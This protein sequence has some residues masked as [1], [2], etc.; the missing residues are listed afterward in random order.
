[1]KT[2]RRAALCLCLASS[3]LYACGGKTQEGSAKDAEQKKGSSAAAEEKA[4][5]ESEKQGKAASEISFMIP[6][7]GVPT[8]EML[9][10]F[11]E[12]SGVKVNVLTTGWDDIRNKISTA[13]AGKTAAADVFEV[14]WSWVGEFQKAGWIAPISLSQEDMDDMVSAKTFSVDGTLYAVPYSNDYRIAYYNKNMFDQA[15]IS[16]PPKTWKEVISDAKLLK[17]KGI[18]EYPVSNP[19]SAD[20]KST[21]TFLWLA[22]T[23]DGKVFNED[24]T[25]NREA[26]LD[27]LN[28]L[29]EINREGLSDPANRAVSEAFP[30]LR[31]G[32][33]AFMVGPSSNVMAVNDPR[34]SKV[35]G[36]V[37]PILL[38][39]KEAQAEVTTPFAEAVGI[40]PYSK[41]PEG[42]KK[43]VEWYSSPEV[44][45]Q[46]YEEISNLPTRTSVLEKLLKDGKI[47]NPGAML[48]LAK[49]IES[50]FPN[51]VPI[52][53]TRMS[54]EIF[55]TIN[56]MANEKL[57]AEE[58]ADQ[59]VEKVNK[60][61]KEG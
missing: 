11:E 45:Y 61:V 55:N 52:Y 3:L 17:E 40:S 31:N 51:G 41:N 12:Q 5:S 26:A 47:Q 50:P 21:T 60:I 43:F 28:I 6:D 56:Q 8:E 16:E 49:R 37:I 36:Q 46:L 19:M 18:C 14:D 42:A 27:A 25:L 10:D 54:T 57:S 38:P 20:E 39:G 48:E 15:G 35:V 22:Y 4:E 58:A 30:R 2:I 23:L 13:A 59:L 44:Q 29:D 33:A 32:E 53:Y 24:N 7:W 9:K 1:M 34:K